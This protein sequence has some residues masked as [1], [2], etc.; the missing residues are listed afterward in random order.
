MLS[1]IEKAGSIEILP[2]Y[3]LGNSFLVVEIQNVRS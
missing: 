3:L 1:T 2:I